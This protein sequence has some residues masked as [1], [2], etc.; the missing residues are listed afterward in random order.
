MPRRDMDRIRGPEQETLAVGKAIGMPQ[1]TTQ[2][3]NRSLATLGRLAEPH[4]RQPEMVG[5]ECECRIRRDGLLIACDRTR[6]VGAAEMALPIQIRLEGGKRGRSD[7]SETEPGGLLPSLPD[8][9]EDIDRQAVD[10]GKDAV[11]RPIDLKRG[12]QRA[13]AHRV[14]ASGDAKPRAPGDDAAEDGVPRAGLACDGDCPSEIQRV[15]AAGFALPPDQY[16]PA[17]DGP[18][19]RD[20]VE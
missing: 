20:P 14:D 3:L 2:G 16:R 11:H 7:S 8:C 17:V 19:A 13:V 10:E 15:L 9:R 12:E 18:E 6:P 5:C 1:A 4:I